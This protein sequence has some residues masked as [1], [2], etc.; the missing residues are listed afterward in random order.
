[1]WLTKKSSNSSS[2]L[3]M[4][5]KWIFLLLDIVTVNRENHCEWW[6]L[7]SQLAFIWSICQGLLN[8][9]LK[10]CLWVQRSKKSNQ[11]LWFVSCLSFCPPSNQACNKIY[12]KIEIIECLVSEWSKWK[13]HPGTEISVCMLFLTSR[14]I[15]WLML[16]YFIHLKK[17]LWGWVICSIIKAKTKRWFSLIVVSVV[18]AKSSD[19]WIF[20]L[21]IPLLSFSFSNVRKCLQVARLS[22]KWD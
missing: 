20:S 12:F 18:A 3:S 10:G 14:S 9:F 7:S 13:V 16:I 17:L 6:K 22:M 15:H 11:I 4:S 2:S 19:S 1:M 8:Y 5:L 21:L